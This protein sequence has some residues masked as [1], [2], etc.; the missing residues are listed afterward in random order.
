MI[1][2]NCLYHFSHFFDKNYSF[3]QHVLITDHILGTSILPRT[4]FWPLRV[5]GDGHVN[6]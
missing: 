2:L 4:W 6:M 5:V 1:F 3:T